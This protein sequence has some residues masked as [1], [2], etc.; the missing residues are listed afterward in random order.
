VSDLPTLVQVLAALWLFAVVRHRAQVPEAYASVSVHLVRD[1]AD[2][3]A[4][5][6]VLLGASLG[7][8][9]A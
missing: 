2:Q 6:L 9:C 7:A 8:L 5:W 1:V 3:C 4:S